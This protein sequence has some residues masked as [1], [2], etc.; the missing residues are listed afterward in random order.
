MKYIST[1]GEVKPIN[2]EDTVLMGL[3]DDGGLLIPEFIPSIKEK[4]YYFENLSYN[5]LAFEIMRLFISD[6]P[7][8][9]LIEIINKSYSRNFYP[10]VAPLKKLS[11]G[12]ILEL[13]TGPTLSFKDVA[14]QFIG[15]LFEYILV[16]RNGFLNILGATSGDTGSAGIYGVKGKNNINIFIMHPYK[17]ISKLQELQMT[18]ILDNNVYNIAIKGSFDDCQR[19]MKEIATDIDFK[20][21][22]RIGAIN[23]VNWARILAQIVYYVY[24]TLKILKETKKESLQ[25][26]VPTGNFGNILAAW[27]AA[28]MG[29]PVSKII[30]ATNENDILSRFFNTGIYS[31]G[32]VVETLSPAMDIQVASNFERYLYYKLNQNSKLLREKME[33]FKKVG[34]IVLD[35]DTVVD[36]LFVSEKATKEEVL[37]IIKEYYEKENYLLD[38]HT[39]VGIVVATKLKDKQ[40]PLLNIATAHP[41]KFPEAI[42]MA[43]GKDIATHPTLEK[44]KGLPT[45]CEIIENDVIKVKDFIE[46]SLLNKLKV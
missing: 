4:L 29:L 12:Y 13:F 28:K 22:Y 19:I 11:S 23:S 2:F 31:V 24:A 38:P 10:E 35:V 37:P 33:E 16:K 20:R 45:K 26:A 46:S 5:E 40:L 14:L 21:K 18:T 41:A 39:A 8:N 34:K 44:L 7:E 17:R 27:Y 32:K 42:F 36:E 9:D 6:I 30:L 15:N 43:L 25:I 1:R 3:A